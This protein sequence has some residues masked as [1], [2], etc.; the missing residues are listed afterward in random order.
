MRHLIALAAGLAVLCLPACTAEADTFQFSAGRIDWAGISSTPVDDDGVRCY[1]MGQALSCV[2]VR[3]AL[4]KPPI[5]E[6][7]S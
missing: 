4:P 7:K 6:D 2:Q 1:T 3:P 5:M